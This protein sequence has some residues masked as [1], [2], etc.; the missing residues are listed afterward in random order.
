MQAGGK[1]ASSG[2]GF[3]CEKRRQGYLPPAAGLRPAA[4]SGIRLPLFFRFP[5][6]AD[7]LENPA[8][9]EEQDG[10][11]AG[12]YS[13]EDHREPRARE[14]AGEKAQ[15]QQREQQR[16]Y[17]HQ[18]V[19][20]PVKVVYSLPVFAFDASEPVKPVGA[21]HLESIIL[22]VRTGRGKFRRSGRA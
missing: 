14:Y 15:D 4:F 7:P 13:E 22:S 19:P 11:G 17:P 2:A 12:N 3:S 9:E 21:A 5:P 18:Q 6:G 16:K 20:D 10:K 8:D 1:P